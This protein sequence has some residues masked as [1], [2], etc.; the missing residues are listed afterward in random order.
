MIRG[1]CIVGSLNW[2]KVTIIVAK[3]KAFLKVSDLFLQ[4]LAKINVLKRNKLHGLGK[5][6]YLCPLQMKNREKSMNRISLLLL[7]CLYAG[8]W[9]QGQSTVDYYPSVTPTGTFVNHDGE[10]EELAI[11]GTYDA[12]LTVTFSANPADTADY[13]VYYEWKIVKVDTD[14]ETTLAVRNDEVT[15]YTFR[16]GGAGINYRV[17]LAITYRNRTT[18][19][20]GSV[21]QDASEILTFSLRSSSLTVFNAFSPNGDGINDVYRVKTQSLL[22]FRMAI[23]NRWGQRIVS[24][25]ESTLEKEYQDDYT[26]YV[27]WDG[28]WHGQ[29]ADDGVY[30]I[31]IEALGS[32][33]ITYTERR[34]INLLTRSRE[35]TTDE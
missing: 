17:S 4:L 33:G 9:A 12:P 2:C 30:F 3:R 22:S 14:E 16:E 28:T 23:F 19:D 18:G 26:Y 32:D 29:T 21:E 20:E 25:N 5:N 1:F 10:E 27:C 7:F 34:D 35:K 24:G 15:E 8:L 6:R 11:G 31:S 13:V